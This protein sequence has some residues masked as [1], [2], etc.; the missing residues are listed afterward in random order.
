MSPAYFGRLALL[1]L[2][3]LFALWALLALVV[4]ALAPAAVRAAS[5][6]KA[7]SG[8]NFLF[9]LRVLPAFAAVFLVAVLCIP[10]YLKFEPPSATEAIGLGGLLAA[11]LAIALFGTATVRSTRALFRSSRYT[12]QAKRSGHAVPRDGIGRIWI[13]DGSQPHVMLAG[14]F[15]PRI[16]VSRRVVES[17]ET[18]HFEAVVRHEQ[19]HGAASDNLKKLL[20]LLAPAPSRFFPGLRSLERAWVRLAEWAADDHATAGNSSNS[21]LL[22]E[23][24]V[25]V[26]KLGSAS[27][28]SSLATTLIPDPSDLSRRVDRLLAPAVPAQAPRLLWAGLLG[29]GI[30]PLLLLQPGPLA[31]LHRLLEVWMD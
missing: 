29:L 21:V 25:R 28:G 16:F 14:L 5:R 18:P 4:S 9:A 1:S 24:L 3:S 15:R 12:R 30:A 6:M 2:A 31:F 20:L 13:L 22:A 19:A 7:G 10:S 26:A 27:H 8:A 17:L 11:G 23:A